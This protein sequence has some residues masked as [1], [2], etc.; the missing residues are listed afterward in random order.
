MRTQ[1]DTDP[2]WVSSADLFK[3]FCDRLAKIEHRVWVNRRIRANDRDI[4][5]TQREIT[6]KLATL[7]VLQTDSIN[8]ARELKRCN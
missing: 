7:R 2:T 8:L 6:E 3:L 5:L 1:K 4:A